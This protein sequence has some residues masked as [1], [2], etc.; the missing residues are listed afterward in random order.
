MITYIS[1]RLLY[2]I[3]V[4]I[5]VERENNAISKLLQ[6]KKYK[7]KFKILPFVFYVYYDNEK[8]KWEIRMQLFSIFIYFLN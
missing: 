1:S 6:T 4:L 3:C 2:Y 5:C 8:E 7:F